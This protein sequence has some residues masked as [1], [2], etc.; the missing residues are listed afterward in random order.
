MCCRV[1]ELGATDN[2]CAV[3]AK[4]LSNRTFNNDAFDD[5][6]AMMTAMLGCKNTVQYISHGSHYLRDQFGKS[7][8]TNFILMQ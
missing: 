2:G 1:S 3:V 8:R 5:E 4:L 7:H 6:V